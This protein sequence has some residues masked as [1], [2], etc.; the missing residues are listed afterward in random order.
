MPSK[1]FPWWG[2][3][4]LRVGALGATGIFLGRALAVDATVERLVSAAVFALLGLF[5]LVLARQAR[6]PEA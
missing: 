1:P 5:W 3:V 6:R 2:Y 4:V